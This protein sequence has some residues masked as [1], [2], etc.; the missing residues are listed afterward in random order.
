MY[1]VHVNRTDV[2]ALADGLGRKFEVTDVTPELTTVAREYLASYEGNFSFL[3]DLRAKSARGLSAGQAKGVLNC[4][5][6][7]LR[8][9]ARP[10]AAPAA[11]LNLS[12][13][14][15][16]RYRVVDGLDGSSSTAV[17]LVKAT[18]ATDKPAGTRAVAVRCAEGWLNLGFLSPTGELSLWRK[19]EAF[20]ARVL[21]SLAILASVDDTLIYGLAYAL[22]GG[23]CYICGSELDTEES[24]AAG[25]GPTC[26]KNRG[27]PWG[28]KVVPAQV[29][30]ARAAA[31]QGAP[32]PVAVAIAERS[33]AAA[34]ARAV[35]AAVARP[36]SGIVGPAFDSPAADYPR[37][38]RSYDEIFADDD[39]VESLPLPKRPTPAYRTSRWSRPGDDELEHAAYG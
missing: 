24:L 5:L 12:R 13:I 11:V 17:R 1:T 39:E 21:A 14:P 6:A 30:L 31:G 22:E 10:A 34:N 7:D 29:L 38:A 19:A 4:L 20:K 27:L 36:G 2:L 35:V 25:Y 23:E 33:A 26:A 37:S 28:A 32:A 18:W 8:R 15:D 3:L 16:G 9:A